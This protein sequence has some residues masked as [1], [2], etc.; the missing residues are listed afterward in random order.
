MG[1]NPSARE[2]SLWTDALNE[3]IRY[4]LVEDKGYKGEVFRVTTI[5]YKNADRI[6]EA[7]GIDTKNSPFD[8]LD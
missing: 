7:L 6:K 2:E 3:L 8:Y 4:G 5:G 1:E